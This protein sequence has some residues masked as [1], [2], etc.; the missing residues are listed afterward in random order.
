MTFFQFLLT[1]IKFIGY[2][3]SKR[4]KIIGKAFFKNILNL[5]VCCPNLA[6]ILR[7]MA[8][9]K[10]MNKKELWKM[11]VRTIIKVFVVC[12]GGFSMKAFKSAIIIK[13]LT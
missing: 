6:S 1:L 5:T 10:L 13:V 4:L 8:M 2:L 11:I 9:N 3:I 12:E 7:N